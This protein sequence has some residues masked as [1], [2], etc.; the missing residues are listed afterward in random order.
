MKFKYEELEV[1]QMGMDLTDK[2]YDIAEKYPDKE[3]FGLT[4]QITKSATSI[5]LNIAEGNGRRSRKD[6]ARYLRIAIGSLLE[7]DTNLKISIRRKY[8][9]ENDY[10]TVGKDIEDL[11]W[12]LIS[13]EKYLKSMHKRSK[14]QEQSES[15]EETLERIKLAIGK[16]IEST[17]QQ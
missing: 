13:F 5:P 3:R 16:T 17:K 2:I 4:I 11:Y 8:I 1:W 10:E 9:T 14:R 12:K 6:F 7:T 15:P